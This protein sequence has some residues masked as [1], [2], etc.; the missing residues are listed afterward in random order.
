MKEGVFVTYQAI[1]SNN[2]KGLLSFLNKPFLRIS[3][4]PLLFLKHF[5]IDFLFIEGS[6]NVDR[7]VS[8]YGPFLF[9]F[10]PF[11]LVGLLFWFGNQL[12]IVVNWPFLSLPER[13]LL[14]YRALLLPTGRTS[15]PA[16]F[17]FH[18]SY[19]SFWAEIFFLA[20]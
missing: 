5:S 3:K 16:V 19:C 9:I 20:F 4:R 7:S 18:F 14:L 17:Y 1:K 15:R 12:I 13:L 2:N 11:Y 8:G 6:N 10:V